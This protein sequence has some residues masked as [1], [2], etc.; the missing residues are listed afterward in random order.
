M[1][2]LANFLRWCVRATPG[3]YLSASLNAAEHPTDMRK[4]R[5]KAATG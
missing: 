4:G 2:R 5:V 1:V 3:T